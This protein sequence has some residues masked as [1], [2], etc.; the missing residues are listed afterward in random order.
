MD[1]ALDAPRAG[2]VLVVDDELDVREIVAE[3][4]T[5][6]GYGVRLAADGRE[7]LAAATGIERPAVLLVDLVMPVMTGNELVSRLRASPRTVDLP[8]VVMTSD[9]ARAPAGLPVLSKPVAIP[10][11]LEAIA[12]AFGREG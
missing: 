9:P 4:L 3:I 11:L 7:G 6:A 12:A 5:D 8:V 10:T 1:M 2:T